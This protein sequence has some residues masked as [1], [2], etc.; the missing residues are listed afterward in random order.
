M[1]FKFEL[2]TLVKAQLSAFIGGAFDYFVMIACTEG[3][4]IYYARSII[5][6]GL[7]GALVNFSINRYWTYNAGERGL[8]TQLMKFYLVVLGSILLKSYGTYYVTE[9]LSI[10]Y[11]ITR[12]IVDLFVSIGFNFVLQ[13]YWVFRKAEIYQPE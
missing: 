13:K 11:R 8:T 1:K 5:I 2:N 7:L 6:S 10:D 9:A 3:L 4:N 12:L